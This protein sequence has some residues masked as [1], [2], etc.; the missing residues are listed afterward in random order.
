MDHAIDAVVE[1]FTW[2]GLG[3]FVVLAVVALGVWAAEGTWLPAS[4]IVDRDGEHPVVRWFDADGD[5]NSAPLT[6]ADAAAL[7]DAETAAIWYR[8]G[9]RGRMR[10]VRRSPGLRAL[11]WSA[12]GM[13]ALGVLSLVAGWVLYFLRG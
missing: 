3:A 4:A 2:I 1:V 9:W 10:L 11:V 6:P 7:A 13:L 5:A 12:A 8:H